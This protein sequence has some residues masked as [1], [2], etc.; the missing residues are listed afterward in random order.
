MPLTDFF[1]P[2][3]HLRM[4]D[5]G[6]NL[7]KKER[8]PWDSSAL[9]LQVLMKVTAGVLPHLQTRASGSPQSVPGLLRDPSYS[10]CHARA[11][12]D[13]QPAQQRVTLSQELLG[14]ALGP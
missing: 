9:W 12:R 6:L 2:F 14:I 1:S 13:C 8:V 5:S 7:G 3:S 4:K 10:E 11:R